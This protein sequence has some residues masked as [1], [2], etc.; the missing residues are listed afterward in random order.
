[1]RNIWMR[2]LALVV[3]AIGL[4]LLLQSTGLGLAAANDLLRAAGGMQ[5][6]RFLAILAAWTETYRLLGAVLLGVGLLSALQA[7]SGTRPHEGAG[8]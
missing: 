6:D 4:F 3:G 5:E 8:A 7:E 2:A 1:M